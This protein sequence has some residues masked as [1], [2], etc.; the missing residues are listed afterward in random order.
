MPTGEALGDDTPTAMIS[1]PTARDVRIP[2]PGEPAMPAAFIEPA[3]EPRRA[4]VVVIHEAYGLDDDIRRIAGR[5]AAAGYPTLA[6]DFFADL[7]PSPLCIA[8]FLRSVARGGGGRAFRRLDAARAWL[9][10]RSEVDG[11]AIGVAGFCMGGGFA[12]LYAASGGIGAVAPFYAAVPRE[13]GALDGICPVVASYGGRDRIFGDHG[14]R[15]R[16]A[17]GA[18]GVEHDVRTYP[19]AGHSFM[20]RH[21]GVTG[22]L[23][24]H[25]PL[26]AEYREDAA[27][28]AWRRTFAFFDRHLGPT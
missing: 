22:W 11:G 7:G 24:A 20:S 8:R 10:A 28:D 15:L 2:V 16:S 18:A 9:A 14:E 26:H 25:L 4:G 23:G 21:D 1:T 3:E 17:L 27:E 12:L 19:D 6:P 13:D 5:F